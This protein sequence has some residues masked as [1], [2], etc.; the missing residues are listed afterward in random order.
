VSLLLPYLLQQQV[1]L[2][3]QVLTQLLLVLVRLV[4]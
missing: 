4:H 2:L 1:L 3:L